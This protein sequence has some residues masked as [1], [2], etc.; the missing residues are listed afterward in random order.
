MSRIVKAI[1][2]KFV[3]SRNLPLSEYYQKRNMVLVIRETGG[4]GDILMMRMI[5]EDLKEKMPE[6]YLVVATPIQ[7]HG[8]LQGHPYID[9]II[10]SCDVDLSDYV[11]S[12]NISAACGKHEK[13][14]APLADKHRADIWANHCGIELD[15]HNMH[16]SV[17]VEVTKKCRRVLEEFRA[18]SITRNY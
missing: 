4:C 5:F 6:S 9:K 10:D 12:Y 14:M 16:L 3:T 11:I 17:P 13:K 1:T 18:L 15:H 8:A 2:S 7:Y